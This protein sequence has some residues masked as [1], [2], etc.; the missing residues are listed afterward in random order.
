LVNLEDLYIM[1][2]NA[3]HEDL[4]RMGNSSSPSF[5]EN[6]GLK[7]CHVVNVDGI[8]IIYA[9]GNGFSAFNSVTSLMKKKGKNVWKIKEGANLTGLV[10]VKDMRKDHVGHYMIA[11]QEKM[12]FKKYLGL[13]EEFG[14][15][16][17]KCIRLTSEEIKNA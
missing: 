12:P 14:S 6:R 11:P 9:N 17:S 3:L 13:L 15:D 16:I 4:Y 8:N 1:D 2:I 10:L 5:S 7:D